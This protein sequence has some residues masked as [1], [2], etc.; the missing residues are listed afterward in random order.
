MGEYKAIRHLSII[1]QS[2]FMI[3]DLIF[4]NL[5]EYLD[6]GTM[7]NLLQAMKNERLI[8]IITTNKTLVHS[9]LFAS[10]NLFCENNSGIEGQN[11]NEMNNLMRGNYLDQIYGYETSLEQN[12][13]LLQK[14]TNYMAKNSALGYDLENYRSI[15]LTEAEF[16]RDWINQST[17]PHN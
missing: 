12:Y 7:R 5:L 3:P 4:E 13:S 11:I 2:M 8:K 6:A 10:N 14:T 17:K 1:S 16:K 15:K 9:M